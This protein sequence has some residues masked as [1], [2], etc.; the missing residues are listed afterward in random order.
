MTTP[1]VN[2]SIHFPVVSS[3]FIYGQCTVE[4]VD[5]LR[6]VNGVCRVLEEWLRLLMQILYFLLH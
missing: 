5:G 6:R 3:L 2:L 1:H 4:R